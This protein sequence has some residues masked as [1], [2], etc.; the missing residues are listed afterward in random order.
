MD[1][2][3][4]AP[5]SASALKVKKAKVEIPYEEN[6]SLY[7][8]CLCTQQALESHMKLDEKVK[9]EMMTELNLLH[10]Y[11]RQT[12]MHEKEQ[13]KR[14]WTLLR[15]HYSCKK[16]S[17]KGIKKEYDYLELLEVPRIRRQTPVLPQCSASTDLLFVEQDDDLED[18]AGT[19]IY[20]PDAPRATTSEADP[21]AHAPTL[22]SASNITRSALPS[23]VNSDSEDYSDEQ[24]LVCILSPF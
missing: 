3:G 13:K 5:V 16:L 4:S 12:L 1:A 20:K 23:S 18:T 10:N 11:A 2:T 9:L 7:E 8:I 22:A 17:S 15:K 19:F 6:P 24:F 21:E 14:S